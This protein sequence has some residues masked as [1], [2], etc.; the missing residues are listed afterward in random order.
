LWPSPSADGRFS[1]NGHLKWSMDL[2]VGRLGSTAQPCF[3][4]LGL[5]PSSRVLPSTVRRAPWHRGTVQAHLR[6]RSRRLDFD[7]QPGSSLEVT[8]IHRHAPARSW[9]KHRALLPSTNLIQRPFVIFVRCSR[10]EWV[11]RQNS[12][13]KSFLLTRTGDSASNSS[14]QQDASS[15]H[16]AS[17]IFLLRQDWIGSRPA[18]IPHLRYD[19]LSY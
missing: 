7:F 3:P 2:G 12:P 18:L 14:K 1:S 13:R 15:H 11:V 5:P 10:F 19:H 8:T 16:I 4:S 17:L 6:S 9:H